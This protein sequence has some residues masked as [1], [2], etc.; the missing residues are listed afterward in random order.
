[1]IHKPNQEEYESMFIHG[2]NNEWTNQGSHCCYRSA[3][4]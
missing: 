4:Y 2:E 1:M 3:D